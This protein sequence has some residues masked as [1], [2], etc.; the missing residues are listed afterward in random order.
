MCAIL[1]FFFKLKQ[2][3]FSAYIFHFNRHTLNKPSEE[4]IF[5]DAIEALGEDGFSAVTGALDMLRENA[6]KQ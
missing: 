4:I 2:A 1:P 5:N 3:A 6:R